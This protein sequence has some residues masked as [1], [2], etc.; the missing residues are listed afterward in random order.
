M[1][2]EL[3]FDTDGVDWEEACQIF[4]KAPL[5]TR[6]P[7]L[8]EQTFKG[9]S[10]VCFAWDGDKLIGLARALS[11]GTLH[12]VIYDL[13]ML[14]EYQGHHLGKRMMEAMLERLGTANTVL[15]SVPGKEGFY[16]RFGFKPMLTA[17][18]RF[19]DPERSAA[20]G[21]IQL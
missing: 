8:L 11:D 10:L 13:C 9:S 15:W 4:E 12:S 16:E 5:G 3:R 17:M 6:Q 14:P 19:E 18:A 21:Y 1:S 7:D 2:I 20:G